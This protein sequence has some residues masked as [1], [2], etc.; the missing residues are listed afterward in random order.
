M[1]N[2]CG[3]SCS[4]FFSFNDGSLSLFIFYMLYN[5][6]SSVSQLSLFLVLIIVGCNDI[7]YF[8]KSCNFER[9]HN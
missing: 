9:T 1:V 8:A 5:V 7:R 2:G 3:S 4:F 6:S